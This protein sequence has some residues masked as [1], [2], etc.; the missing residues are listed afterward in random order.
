MCGGG[1]QRCGG[2]EQLA[3]DAVP[4]GL[5]V[6][7]IGMAAGIELLRHAAAVVNH[8]GQPV[9]AGGK[10]GAE[11]ID[12][13]RGDVVAGAHGQA[14]D[15][16][17]SGFGALQIEI[18]VLA[19]PVGGYLHLALIPGAALVAVAARQVGGLIESRGGVA[20]PVGVGGAWQFNG[21]C[22]Q[23]AGLDG[24][25]AVQGKLPRPAQVYARRLSVGNGVQA[26]QHSQ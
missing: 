11:A 17:L 14:I 15:I 19:V 24:V 5:G 26:E 7:G 1:L 20:F 13:R 16:H 6:L 23:V 21:L 2:E 12:L 9:A 3:D 10:H 22:Q 4:V 18:D 25:L 8:D